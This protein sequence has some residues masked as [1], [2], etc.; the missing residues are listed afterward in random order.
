MERE[1]DT[2][3]GRAYRTVNHALWYCVKVMVAIIS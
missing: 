2:V 3:C 1:R